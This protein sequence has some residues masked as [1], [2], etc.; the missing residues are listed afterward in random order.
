VKLLEIYTKIFEGLNQG[1]LAIQVELTDDEKILARDLHL[2]TM[3]PFVYAANVNESDLAMDEKTLREKIGVLDT[4]IPV[5]LIC[6]KI[7]MEMMEFGEE[8][9]KAFLADLGLT[10]NPVDELIKTCFDTLGLQYYFTA[11]EVEARAWTINK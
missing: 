1:K 4:N 8:D 5:V 2:L 9:R 6:A 11:G 7:E 10:K 3:K